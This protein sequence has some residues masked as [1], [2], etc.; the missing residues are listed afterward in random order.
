[1]ALVKLILGD[2]AHVEL[3]E[4]SFQLILTDPPYRRDLAVPLYEVLARRSHSLLGE[5][6]SLLM[7][8]PH[9]LVPEVVTEMH[10]SPMR[11]RWI[12]NMDQEDGPHPRMAMGIEVCWKPIL[13]YVKGTFPAR[14][15]FIRDKV[16]IRAPE[17]HL[18]D[19]QQAESWAEY[20]IE[21]FTK[22]G[23]TILD[24]FIGTGTVAA[25]GMRME[26]NVV[27]IDND[28]QMLEKTWRRLS[29]MV[30]SGSWPANV[31]VNNPEEACAA[32]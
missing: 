31:V 8:V 26:R 28:E 9:Y 13:H 18:H 2:F 30:C 29:P 23:D 4:N 12:Y 10:R 19:W 20:F 1:M 15:G 21:K 6:G 25:V 7:I 22:P 16:P 24:P 27:G 5:H 3:P 11:Y 17:K 32:N 14:Q